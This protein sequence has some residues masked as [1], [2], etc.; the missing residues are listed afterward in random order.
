MCASRTNSTLVAVNEAENAVREL[1][2]VCWTDDGTALKL[3]SWGPLGE[4]VHP[5]VSTAMHTAMVLFCG[6]QCDDG[7]PSGRSSAA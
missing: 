2:R 3:L 1:A 7:G 6:L 5:D 4:R